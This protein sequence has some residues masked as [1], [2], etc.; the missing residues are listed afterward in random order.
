[1]SEPTVYVVKDDV[2]NKYINVDSLN[3][4]RF[5]VKQVKDSKN[6]NK[7]TYLIKRY[8][9][10]S[11]ITPIVKNVDKSL[12]TGPFPDD[13]PYYKGD[14]NSYIKINGVEHRYGVDE[15]NNEFLIVCNNNDP[16]NCI[17]KARY[18]GKDDAYCKQ[19]EFYIKKDKDTE[20]DKSSSWPKWLIAS[21][22]LGIIM[23]IGW[24]VSSRSSTIS[25]L[26]AESDIFANILRFFKNGTT[27]FMIPTGMILM[28]G[29]IV[30]I[31]YNYA[32]KKSNWCYDPYHTNNLKLDRFS[33]RGT[34][35][36]IIVTVSSLIQVGMRMAGADKS[37]LLF[38][39]GFILAFVIGYMGDKVI[40]T[41][42]GYAIYN[43]DKI[44]A[45]KY[46]MGS[47]ASPE[48]FRFIIT[49]FLDMFISAPIQLTM[50]YLFSNYTAGLRTNSTGISL[51]DT[52]MFSGLTKLVG[53]NF[54]T[55]LQSIVA[56]ITFM[57]YTND[58]RFL[59]AYPDKSLLKEERMSSTTIRLAAVIAGV[60]FL[61]SN[62]P[63]LSGTK[64]SGAD[65]LTDDILPGRPMGPS[66]TIKMIYIVVVIIL[67]TLGAY[68]IGFSTDADSRYEVR[69]QIKLNKDTDKYEIVEEIQDM[70]N[71][72]DT[73]KEINAKWW[74]GIIMF[75]I[76]LSLGFTLPLWKGN[77]GKPIVQF[78]SL[79]IPI[80]IIVVVAIICYSKNK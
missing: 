24:F 11:R 25:P 15:L 3:R 49:V 56:I 45:L 46:S 22:V 43:K 26:I 78:V 6:N 68:N 16:T 31:I 34:Y 75:F 71:T 58:T 20:L 79:L 69:R 9:D 8:S 67:L 40:G 47:L 12:D 1:M 32:T 37:L 64:D 48:F 17:K 29:L 70:A 38:M 44:D 62:Y 63:D 36:S 39:Y 55:I 50:S 18:S 33:N 73:S 51:L 61:V 2:L 74:K 13:Q 30:Y 77:Q 76:F 54:D 42:E 7:I 5:E 59:W 23:I 57:A 27:V 80:I 4:R 66:L 65:N 35:I 14:Y 53:I 52:G 60:V 21:I 10:N 28:A 72:L 41:E 19:D